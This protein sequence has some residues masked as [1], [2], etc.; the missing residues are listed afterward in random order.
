MPFEAS[1]TSR[2]AKAPRLAVN[3]VSTALRDFWEKSVSTR[4]KKSS[5]VMTTGVSVCS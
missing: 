4:A 2:R 3:R 1:V 5:P